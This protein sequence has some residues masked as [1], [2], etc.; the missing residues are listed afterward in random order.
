MLN[1]LAQNWWALALRGVI[2]VLF[3]LTAFA[4]PGLTLTILIY[5]FAAYLVV[6]GIFALVAGLRAAERHERWGMLALEGAANLVAGIVIFLWP[7]LTLL[8]F[9]YF[10]GF[11]AIISGV[12]LLIDAFRL[13]RQHGEWWMILAG[14]ASLVWG[15]LVVLFP[16][17]GIL[18]WAWWIAAYALIFGIAMLVLAFRLRA[19]RP[20]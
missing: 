14:L 11:W 5:F 3:G 4:M 18:V 15:V 12:A 10:A 7:G 1:I 19:R 13:H 9:V 8:Y 17:A 6:D 20:A 2:A 16:V